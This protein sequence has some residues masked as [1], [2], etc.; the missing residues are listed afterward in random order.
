METPDDPRFDVM[1]SR[2]LVTVGRDTRNSC[3]SKD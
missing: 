2:S 1:A 3:G